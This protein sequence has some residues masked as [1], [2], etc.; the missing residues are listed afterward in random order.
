MR[1]ESPQL[2]VAGEVRGEGDIE[3][4]RA[5]AR[6]CE[7]R[8]ESDAEDESCGIIE[9]SGPD[10][11]RTEG[12]GGRCV[13]MDASVCAPDAPLETGAPAKEMRESIRR[14]TR[15]SGRRHAH[16]LKG[17]VHCGQLV[18][19]HS[20]ELIRCL[21]FVNQC[22]IASRVADRLTD[23]QSHTPSPRLEPPLSPASALTMRDANFDLYL[24]QLRQCRHLP[25]SAMKHLCQIVR[26]ILME[27][28]NVQPVSSPVTVCGDIHGQ[29]WDLLELLKV[30][31]EAPGTSYIFMVRLAVSGQT[32]T[33]AVSWRGL[34]LVD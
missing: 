26:S 32:R 8:D 13:R 6:G 1:R 18:R 31:G 33:K 25:E 4:V 30:G 27:E 24:T 12:T 9:R 2:V 14:P 21:L 11:W 15:G 16:A 19:L 3:Q 20:S 5:R 10:A 29:L 34:I 17:G 28:S 23:T 22:K 7:D